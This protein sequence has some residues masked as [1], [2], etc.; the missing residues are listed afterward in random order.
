MSQIICLPDNCSEDERAEIIN[1]YN[2]S[3]CGFMRTDHSRIEMPVDTVFC[4][5]CE[6]CKPAVFFG[7][8]DVLHVCNTCSH[9]QLLKDFEMDQFTFSLF[10]EE[11]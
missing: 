10:D 7:I 4:A 3:I 9:N 11:E 1:K 8:S 5:H 2:I 6:T